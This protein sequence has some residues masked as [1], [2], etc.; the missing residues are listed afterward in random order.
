MLSVNSKNSFITDP[1][2]TLSKQKKPPD[3]AYPADQSLC[4][5]THLKEYLQR[6]KLLRGN[7]TKLLLSHAKPHHR[8]SRDTIS[9]WIHSIMAEAGVDV[10]TFKPHS[11][12]TLGLISRLLD[13]KLDKKFA[14]FKRALEQKELST[15]SQIKK[16]KT[17]AKASSSFQFKGNKLQFEFNSSLLDSINNALDY[18][19]EE[20]LS[21]VNKELD[22]VKA[23]LNKR[24][25]V[26]RFADKS[27]ASWAAVEEYESDELA[28]D[29][30]NEKKL[31]S[32]ERRVLSKIRL[33]KQSR[34]SGQTRK[35]RQ[36]CDGSRGTGGSSNSSTSQPFRHQPFTQQ[37]FRPL[38]TGQT[39]LS[40]LATAAPTAT[41]PCQLP[42]PLPLPNKGTL[43]RPGTDEY[44]N[45]VDPF[46]S[47]V[48]IE[49]TDLLERSYVDYFE[50]SESVI[51]NGRLRANVQ[52]WESIGARAL[53]TFGGRFTDPELSR[54]ASSLPLRCL[55]AKADSTVGRYSRAFEKFR[56]W[57]TG[58]R[59]I[60]VLPTSFLH[61]ATY[62]EFLVQS[63]SPYSAL[64]A[65][66]YGIRWVHYLFGLSNPCDSN[67]VKGILES[68]KRSLSRLI[69]KKESVTPEMVLSICRK[70][71]SAN[72]NLSDLCTA[73]ICV[74]AFAGF[75]HFN[76]LANLHCC[77]VKFCEDKYLELL[78][79][80]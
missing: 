72:A 10:T 43:E 41:G 30:E 78:I 73:A 65:A 77:D 33:R 44:C 16:L 69:V 49:E 53:S 22:N 15:N 79:A 67:L 58:Y 5:F 13:S 26:I 59:E 68:A 17:E 24:N 7:E 29:S 36:D 12:E 32:A 27:P 64:E 8:A 66:R 55:G 25:K 56:L 18:L 2:R 4:V 47:L 52:F 34:S 46:S 45:V 74:T 14:D 37:S 70:F 28:N 50:G 71:A 40:V 42:Q 3:N 60:S 20:D 11:E 38:G 57:A 23:S 1:M 21:G 61:V 19:H 75:L 76:E 62:L 6:T 80:K 9:R 51:V 39:P 54:L 31:R 48:G 63:N 35:F